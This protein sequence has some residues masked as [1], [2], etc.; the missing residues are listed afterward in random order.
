MCTHTY[1]D[2]S[3]YVYIYT[4][5]HG[6]QI[7]QTGRGLRSQREARGQGEPDE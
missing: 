7:E 1:L 4:H 5:I 2:L 6:T 3:L